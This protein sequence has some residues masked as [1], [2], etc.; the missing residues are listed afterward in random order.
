MYSKETTNI[1]CTSAT[2]GIGGKSTAEPAL[3]PLGVA[4]AEIVR[5]ALPWTKQNSVI[6]Y[7]FFHSILT[8]LNWEYKQST[9][10]FIFILPYDIILYNEWP[11]FKPNRNFN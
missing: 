3:G 9:E 7:P 10:I 5:Q 1:A 8:L 2:E 6:F 4:Q 11:I